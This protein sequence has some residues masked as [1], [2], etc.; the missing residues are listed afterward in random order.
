ME[1]K[2]KV[3]Y[4]VMGLAILGMG[5]STL[6]DM[7]SPK[8][9]HATPTSEPVIVSTKATS[10][11]AQPLILELSENALDVL[12][13][14]DST[15][16]SSVKTKAIN[17]EIQELEE[18][19]RLD[20]LKEEAIYDKVRTQSPQPTETMQPKKTPTLSSILKGFTITSII[21]NTA[22]IDIG[23]QILSV[24][25]G[26]TIKGVKIVGINRSAV[27]FQYKHRRLTKYIKA[28]PIK[29]ANQKDKMDGKQL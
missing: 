3:L 21:N 23:G 28:A 11:I 24:K 13:A 15:Y 7:L 26:D 20:A 27:V 6:Y 2:K 8:P 19:R 18:Q 29:I 1:T 25:K 16:L 9:T 14:L 22:F 5:T 17:A 4:V 12:N 10:S